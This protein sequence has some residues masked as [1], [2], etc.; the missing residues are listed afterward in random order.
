MF[1]VRFSL[2]LLV[3]LLGIH[4]L[5]QRRGEAVVLAQPAAP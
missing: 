1:P 3:V 2:F 5:A 4:S